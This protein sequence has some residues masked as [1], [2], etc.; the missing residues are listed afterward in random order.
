MRKFLFT[1]E[2]HHLVG[3]VENSVLN[4]LC[5]TE[6]LGSNDLTN[7][8]VND[9]LRTQGII[10]VTRQYRHL[11]EVETYCTLTARDAKDFTEHLTHMMKDLNMDML[12]G[13]TLRH[14]I[15]DGI[16]RFYVLRG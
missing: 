4:T 15:E 9:I 5:A 16:L 6:D 2:A 7:Y 11:D 8:W 14:D 3:I 13:Q 12:N 1:A 10:P